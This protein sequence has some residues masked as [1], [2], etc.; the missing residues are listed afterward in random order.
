MKSR[1]GFLASQG[2]GRRG[3]GKEN[4]IGV[5]GTHILPAERGQ[6]APLSS[7]SAHTL[8]RHPLRSPVCAKCLHFRAIFTDNFILSSGH[9]CRTER[10]ASVPELTMVCERHRLFSV[11]AL[12]SA[13]SSCWFVQKFA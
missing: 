7:L 8:N 13:D 12:C 3:G 4:I 10:L 1:I 11:T 6:A 5:A 2:R 9:R